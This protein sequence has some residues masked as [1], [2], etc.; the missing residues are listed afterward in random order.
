MGNDVQLAVIAVGQEMPGAALL[1]AEGVIAL[2]G[3]EAAGADPAH[4]EQ[5]TEAKL[6]GCDCQCGHRIE[7]LPI[8]N[9]GR[10]WK[11]YPKRL[12][13]ATATGINREG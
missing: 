10:Q 7:F 1:P 12:R 9:A 3:K 13:L 11:S 5:G 6:V 4:A 2:E 8:S